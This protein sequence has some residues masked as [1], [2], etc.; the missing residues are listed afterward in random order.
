M[1]ALLNARSEVNELK[2]EAASFTA[3]L[4]VVSEK[5]DY[6]IQQFRVANNP[7]GGKRQSMRNNR[8]N[9]KSK[10]RRGGQIIGFNN[11]ANPVYYK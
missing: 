6:G 2:R 4:N 8:K 1:Q 9:R 10:S 3:R 7:Q 11:R 5:L